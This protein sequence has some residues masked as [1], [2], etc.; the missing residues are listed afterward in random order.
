[1]ARTSE[2]LSCEIIVPECGAG[3]DMLI[4]GKKILKHCGPWARQ[5]SQV[6]PKANGPPLQPVQ[7]LQDVDAD[8]YFMAL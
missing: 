2:L 1:M 4:M 5:A 8:E 7:D 3:V 6:P